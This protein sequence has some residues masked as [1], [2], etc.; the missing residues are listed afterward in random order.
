MQIRC[1]V[2]IIEIERV[3]RAYHRRPALFLRRFFSADERLQLAGRPRPEKSLAARVAAKE[4]VMKLLGVGIGTV[5]WTDM[6]ILSL[7]SGEPR[8]RLRGRAAAIARDLGI[9]EI[10]LSISHGRELA[11]AQAVALVKK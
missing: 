2:D 9:G 6:E 5:A 1:G 8:V 4:A 7:A 3:A 10:S 11:V